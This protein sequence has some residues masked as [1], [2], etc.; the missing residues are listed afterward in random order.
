MMGRLAQISRH[1]IKSHG[2]ERLARTFLRPAECLPWDRHWAVAHESANLVPGWNP[3]ANFAIGSKAPAVTAITAQLDE[4]ESMVTLSAP[5]MPDLAFRPDDPSDL[6][7]FLDWIRPLHPANRSAPN[8][9]A[10]AGRG[11]TDTDYPSVSLLN[12]GSNAALSR[13]MGM[14]LSADRWRANLWIDG[15]PEWVERDWIG[16]EIAIGDAVLQVVEHIVRCR[17]TMANP[18]T[19]VID[20]DTLAA[21]K[22]GHG[23]QEMGVYA[24]VIKGGS[25]TKGDTVTVL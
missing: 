17:A 10:K 22:R 3:C 8:R 21:L 24:K 9:I 4:L 11:M 15:M 23:H 25:I 12:L 20:A 7:R 2:R 5:G 18:E 6:P 1:P 16:R 14:S 13:E 19:G